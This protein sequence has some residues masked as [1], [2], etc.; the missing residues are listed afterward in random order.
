M[1]TV[2]D[3][4]LLEN[5]LRVYK[6]IKIE[7]MKTRKFA[8]SKVMLD[9]ALTKEANRPDRRLGDERRS[10]IR[11]VRHGRGQCRLGPS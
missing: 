3:F 1:S 10:G 5:D 2:T 4:T 7:K 6:A 9:R 8:I 11:A